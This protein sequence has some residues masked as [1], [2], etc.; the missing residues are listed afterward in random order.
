MSKNFQKE[1]SENLSSKTEISAGNISSCSP[2][3]AARLLQWFPVHRT[4]IKQARQHENWYLAGPANF[5]V[6]NIDVRH[7][8]SRITCSQNYI[9]HH[10]VHNRKSLD[11]RHHTNLCLWIINCSTR[12]NSHFIFEMSFSSQLVNPAFKL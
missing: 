11:H 7:R 3:F 5:R 12:K 8:L 6:V 4:H 2:S 1:I 10:D 9:I